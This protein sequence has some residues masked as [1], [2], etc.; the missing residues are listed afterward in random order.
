M[1]KLSS[2]RF[3]NWEIHMEDSDKV[4]RPRMIYSYELSNGKG[5][6]D[7]LAIEGVLIFRKNLGAWSVF[8]EK[9]HE[10]IISHFNLNPG[11]I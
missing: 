1:M 6:Y 5:I 2:N 7:V 9:I 10:E 11:D 8:P 4:I 3:S